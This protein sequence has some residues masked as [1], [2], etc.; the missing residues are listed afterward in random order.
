MLL[1]ILR[2]SQQSSID[3]EIK[4]LSFTSMA[5]PAEVPLRQPKQQIALFDEQKSEERK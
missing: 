3:D 4:H 5:N 1:S 2:D